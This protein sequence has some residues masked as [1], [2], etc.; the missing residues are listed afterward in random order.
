MTEGEVLDAGIGRRVGGMSEVARSREFLA[1]AMQNP[2]L[3]SNVTCYISTFLLENAWIT[4]DNPHPHCGAVRPWRYNDNQPDGGWRWRNGDESGHARC[5]IK[6]SPQPLWFSFRLWAHRY[7]CINC[8]SRDRTL[9]PC[10]DHALIYKS[11]ATGQLFFMMES[12]SVL[13]KTKIRRGR[14]SRIRDELDFL[15]LWAGL[16]IAEQNI[17]H[18]WNIVDQ[19]E[20]H[21]ILNRLKVL[22][23]PRVMKMIVIESNTKYK[24][25]KAL[26]WR[27]VRP[28]FQIPTIETGM[29]DMRNSR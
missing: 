12:R 20:C 2:L 11:M 25:T 24:G 1:F 6:P 10:V 23:P 18:S 28:C 15:N 7:L 3:Y 17:N 19:D 26:D 29:A 27:I 4:G 5:T 8:I 13:T 9:R 21:R 22:L 14:R 16:N